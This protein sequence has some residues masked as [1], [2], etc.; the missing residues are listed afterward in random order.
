MA[1]LPTVTDAI[2]AGATLAKGATTA[3]VWTEVNRISSDGETREVPLPDLKKVAQELKSRFVHVSGERP[4]RGVFK[5]E[6]FLPGMTVTQDPFDQGELFYSLSHLYHRIEKLGYDVEA[7]LGSKHKGVPHPIRAFANFMDDLNAYF[8]P[9][10]DLLAFGRGDGRW[11]LASDDDVSVHEAGHMILDHINPQLGGYGDHEGGAIHEAFGDAL[12]AIL[13]NDPEMSEDFVPQV[14][15]APDKKDGLRIVK[16]DLKLSDVTSEVHDRG[17]VYAGFFWSLYEYLQIRFELEQPVAQELAL[18]LLIHHAFHYN[19]SQPDPNDFVEAVLQGAKSL[20]KTKRSP[21]PLEALTAT[22]EQEA[23]KRGLLT[24]SPTPKIVSHLALSVRAVQ[25]HYARSG[26]VDFVSIS[27]APYPGGFFRTYQQRYRTKNFG[28][29]DVVGH[30][31]QSRHS[32]HGR[33]TAVLHR[34][35]RPMKRGEINENVTVSFA[36]AFQKAK[37]YLQRELT[38]VKMELLSTNPKPPF[39]EQVTY[40]WREL[41]ERRLALE[42]CRDVLDTMTKLEPEYVVVGDDKEISY[43]IQLKYGTYYVNAHTGNILFIK[44]IFS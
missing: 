11:H 36:E 10:E 22:I 28:F 43:A 26:L 33:T 4:L 42:L 41:S 40:K 16:N 19:T 24:P 30:G 17:R 7:I 8:S 34:D 44:N 15:R 20:D 2:L 25:K 1:G 23:L 3:L 32:Q 29:V 39:S 18:R 35:I 38:Q 31:M 12:A 6:P 27:K 14:G 5:W 9:S 13:H 21:I 37:N